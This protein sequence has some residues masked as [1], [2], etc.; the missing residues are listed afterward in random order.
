ML[1]D[2][3]VYPLLLRFLSLVSAALW[4]LSP[5]P[6]SPASFLASFLPPLPP[7]LQASSYSFYSYCC[8]KTLP[9]LLQTIYSGWCKSS[10]CGAGYPGGSIG[11]LSHWSVR[12]GAR[13][14]AQPLE[15]GLTWEWSPYYSLKC[16]N[17]VDP[18]T[19]Q[20]WTVWLRLFQ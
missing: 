9:I 15:V 5:L 16:L 11:T 6:P 19:T 8:H 7:S 3:L 12:V 10:H 17:T 18:W 1:F 20:V 14:Q 2:L 13:G 4:L